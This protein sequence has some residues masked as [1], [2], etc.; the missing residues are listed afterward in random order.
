MAK[1]FEETIDDVAKDGV[2]DSWESADAEETSV[3][4]VKVYNLPMR[5][6]TSIKVQKFQPSDIG[7]DVHM[8]IAT[9]KRDFD[10][11]D[12]TL[13]DASVN[14]IAYSLSKGGG[15][16]VI[17]QDDGSNATVFRQKENTHICRR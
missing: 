11:V 15:I 12:R 7:L 9:L 10:Q 16:R 6:F 5:P 1:A 2:A 3:S 14:H 4:P 13:T 8:K 17:R